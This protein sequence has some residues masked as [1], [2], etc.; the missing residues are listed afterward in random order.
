MSENTEKKVL[1]SGCFDMLHSGHIAFIKSAAKYGKVYVCL[2]SDQTIYNLKKRYPINSEQ[3]RKYVLEALKEVHEVCISAGSGYLDFLPEL[4]RIQPHVFVV[5]EDGFSKEK[6]LLCEEKQIELVVLKREPHGTLP[7]RSTTDLRKINRI[8]YRIDLAGGWLDQ[9]FVSIH[10]PGAVITISIEP[11]TEFNERSGMA[12]S[13]RNVATQLWQ[14]QLPEGNEEQIAKMLFAFENPPGKTE[15]AGSQDSIGIV[16][17]GLAKSHYSGGYWPSSIE[18]N[19]E[20]E[21]LQFLES[22]LYLVSLGPRQE[23]YDVLVNTQI[24]KARAIALAEAAENCWQAILSKD[25]RALG[26]ALTHSFHAQIA[27]FPNMV[28]ETILAKIAEYKNS[29]LG[30]KVSGAGGGGYLILVSDEPIEGAQQ[31]TIRR[32]STWL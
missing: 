26:S 11:E 21:V 12:S 17:A 10:A 28:D 31:I 32:R 20:E 3:E 13:T 2:G 27:M 25:C 6:E 8:P 24:S 4:E 29:A 15:I 18:R 14:N 23:G 22:N 7:A 9:P 19:L 5:N 16:F 1:V 30:W